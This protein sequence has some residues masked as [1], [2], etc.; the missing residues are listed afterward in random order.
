MKRVLE[1]FLAFFLRIALWFRYRIEVRGLEKLNKE[2]LN[3]PGGVLFLPNHPTVF[4][5][6]TVITIALWPKYPLRPLIV[7][8]MYEL[9]I[10]NKVMKLLDAL[11][12]P[13]FAE[14]SNSIKRKKTEKVLLAVMDGLRKKQNFLIFPAGHLKNSSLEVIGGASATQK[15]VQETPEANVVLV[16]VKGLWGSS[17]SRALTGKS[18]FLFPTVFRGMKHVLKNLLFFT[19]RRKVI[20]E[21]EPAPANFP[22]KASRIDFNKYLENWYNQPDGLNQQAGKSPGDS[23][24]FVSYSLWKEELPQLWHSESSDDAN[25]QVSRIPEEIQKK[26]IAKITELMAIEPSAVLPSMALTTD[27]GMDSLDIAEMGAFLQDQYDISNI[28]PTD[29]TTVAKVM[30]LAANE[31]QGEGIQEEEEVRITKWQQPVERERAYIHKGETLPEVFLNCCKVKGNQVACAD[32]RAGVVTYSQLKLRTMVLAEYI[33]N[34]P[35]KYVG[36]LLPAGVAASMTILACQLAGKIPLM[37]NWTVGTRHLQAVVQLSNVQV[38]LTSWAFIDRLQNIDFDGIEDKL[39][40]LEDVRRQIGLK[41]KLTSFFKS[42][43]S[44]KKI[45][46][47]FKYSANKESEAVLLFTSG[48]ESMPK[49]VPLSHHNILSNQRAALEAIEIFSD[50]VVFGILPPFH[51]FGFTIS[52]LIGLL[53]GVR[54]AFSPDPTDGKRLAAAF[55]KWGVTIVLGAPTFIKGMIKAATAVQLKTLRLCVTGAEKMPPDLIQAMNELDKSEH[56]YEGYG[57]TEC[58]PI[59]T[60]T[61][62]GKPRKGVGQ[63]LSN[64][65]LCIVDLDTHVPVQSEKQGL[66]LAKGPNVFKGYLNPGI[67]SPFVTVNDQQW[68]LTGDLGYLDQEGNLYLSGRLKRFIKVGGEMIS[69]TSLEDALGKA[70][71]NHQHVKSEEGPVLA[72]CGK[73][74]PGEKPRI[75]LY[76]RFPMGV[77]EAN[78]I[79]RNAGFSN[80]V[81]ISYVYQLDEIPL[82][83]SGKVNYRKLEE[84]EPRHSTTALVPLDK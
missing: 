62:I 57:I 25:I 17:F 47:S 14:S 8:Y 83:G 60:F 68:Y 53:C 67:A 2:T 73:E 30:A 38:V 78:K 79:L 46:S 29:L 80:L 69:L 70:V 13:N 42:K 7:E 44:T 58:S 32:M 59:L 28:S 33:R 75:S 66:I 40:M 65:E 49:G 43:W 12:V 36:I 18:P 72:I 10:V 27:L 76:C 48:T 52:G 45:L 84:E 71:L 41:N 54:I 3:K 19:P 74:I 63:P 64:V 24:I 22:F 51:S 15:I 50:D 34:L 39:V 20:I 56:L 1:F 77:D 31:V 21:F 55:E 11:P 5:D 4:V 35:G 9:P 37:V 6:A 82:M 81:K 23:L 26:V 61:P 16:R